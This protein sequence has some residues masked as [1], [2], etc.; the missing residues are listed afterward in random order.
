LHSSVSQLLILIGAARVAWSQARE[1]RRLREQQNRPFVVID[2]DIER[3]V[4]TFLEISNLGTSLAR[5]VK[6]EIDPPLASS[7]DVPVEKFKMLNE[8]IATLAPGKRLRTFFDMGFQRV[9][10]DLPMAYTAT[11]RYKDEDGKR[12]FKETL[13]L[14]LELFMYLETATRRDVHDVNER[15]KEIRDA[16]RKWGWS[17]GG[18][19]TISR[20]EAD[21]KTRQRREEIEEQ[22]R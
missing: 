5:D 9:N 12:S 22:R 21:E 19:L 16:L 3:G 18:L 13:D 8:G 2:F 14:D 7:V 15:L 1:A 20:A 10:S 11:V 6:F 17:S 4:E